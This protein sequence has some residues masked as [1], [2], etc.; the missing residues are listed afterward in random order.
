[1]LVSQSQR[2]KEILKKLSLNP[3]ID[4]QFLNT[5]L[6]LSDYLNEIIRSF[7]KISQKKFNINLDKFSEKIA[8][9]KSTEIIYGLRNFI[10]N[11]NKFSKKK[12]LG[13]LFMI[14]YNFITLFSIVEYRIFDE[15]YNL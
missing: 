1:M 2:C 9:G 13:F 8:I 7:E 3:Q 15:L 12:Y 10:G 4:D 5:N 6:Y 14:F 11:A